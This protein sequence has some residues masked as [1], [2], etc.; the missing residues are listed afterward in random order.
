MDSY[1]AF[2][3]F[4]QSEKIKSA[5][6]WISHSLEQLSS[7][8]AGEKQGAEKIIRTLLG[9]IAHETHLSR[10]LA[11]GET[12]KEVAKH[13]DQ[14]MV[15]IYSGVPQEATFHLTRALTQVTSISH[16]SMSV[17]KEKGFFENEE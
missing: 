9:M 7:F 1:E 17:L 4:S 2:I 14:A 5:L 11:R 10:R 12:W 8:S 3:A 15:M 16:E 6:I 13:I